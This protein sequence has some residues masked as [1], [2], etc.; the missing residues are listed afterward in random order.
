MEY[1]LP[2]IYGSI[3]IHIDSTGV[4]FTLVARSRCLQ[5]KFFGDGSAIPG[6]GMFPFPVK[7]GQVRQR[8]MSQLGS[9]D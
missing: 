7:N 9:G 4:M 6:A 8:E 1:V 3:T 2:A 5:F